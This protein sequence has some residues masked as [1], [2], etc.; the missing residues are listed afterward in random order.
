MAYEIDAD[1]GAAGN[2]NG[3]RG[4]GPAG[5][6][7]HHA[8]GCS[9]DMVPAFLANGTSAHYGVGPG[10]VRQFLEDDKMAWAAG[11][12]WANW[13]LLHV[14][15]VN[16]AGEP[17]WP[18][19]EETVDTLVEFLADKCREHGIGRLA[20]G[21]N[22]FGHRD[23]YGTF[24]PGALYDRLDEIANR[25]NARLNG[26]EDDMPTAQEIARAVW[27]YD[28]DEGM[29]GGNCFEAVKWTARHAQKLASTDASGAEAETGEH[30][31][32]GADMNVRLS[33]MEARQM[34]M[35]RALAAIAEK[36]GVA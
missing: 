7:I 35:E 12:S 4:G 32:T 36:L 2:T 22:L 31:D 33:Y 18:V 24:C 3:S 34:K 8:A 6:C 13:N 25:V 28:Y 14:E 11:H 17:D 16:S 9:I 23:F 5:F 15:C 30:V 19:A 29:P 1:W 10:H 20:V 27:E 21:E 26:E